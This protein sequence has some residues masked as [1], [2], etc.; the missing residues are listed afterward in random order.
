MGLWPWVGEASAS[1]T[2][3]TEVAPTLSGK[4]ECSFF[5][6]K[7]DIYESGAENCRRIEGLTSSV[8]LLYSKYICIA[9]GLI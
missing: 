3:A 1:R 8:F 7:L 4:V 5:Y 9:G 6:T 2:R